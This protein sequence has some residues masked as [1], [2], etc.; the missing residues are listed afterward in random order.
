MTAPPGVRSTGWIC[1]LRQ[2]P[3][4]E[5]VHDGIDETL[6]CCVE[7]CTCRGMLPGAET[8]PEEPESV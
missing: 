2:C 1:L 3:H 7:G 5:L 8:D 4:S 6:T